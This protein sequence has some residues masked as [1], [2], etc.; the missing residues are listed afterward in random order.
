MRQRVTIRQVAVGF[1]IAGLAWSGFSLNERAV[2][3]AAAEG[4]QYE[5]GEVRIP[6]ASADEPKRSEL[7]VSLAL[8]H[9][10][11]GAVA[12]SG[13]RKCVT[14]HTNGTY[15]VVR[16]ALSASLG[17]P[18]EATWEFFRKTLTSLQAEERSSLRRSTK[19]AQVI[20][21]AAGL[22]EW[23]AHVS[24][25]LLPE[26]EQ[27]LG[28]MFEI[29][30]ENGTWGTLDCWPPYESDAYHEATV[31]A[32]AA[33]TAPGYL[34]KVEAS[35]N[36]TLKKSIERLQTYLRNQPPLHDYSRILL[37]WAS[38]RWPN[39]I[40]STRQAELIEVVR[41]HQ[42]EDGGW[43]IRTFATPEAW[44]RGNRAAKLRAET[45]F[46]TPASDGHMTGLA[47]V[48][49]RS[50]GVPATD[51]AIAR[52]IQWIKTNQ[53]VSG[54]WWTRSLNTDSWH[55]ITYSGTAFPLLALDL[56][57]EI[58]AAPQ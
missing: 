9:L 57:G 54:R 31:A 13:Q 37:L 30:E 5:F 10:E 19:P 20:Y 56:C 7:S 23:D 16:P 48:A 27:A 53:R 6:A 26:T 39:L 24:G 47:V 14:C 58:K 52:G 49:L 21:V 3:V 28:L 36:E 4:V 8:Q 55:F 22:A 33:A 35:D 12:W 32:M 42:R 34:A 11:E 50:A 41:K 1:V 29:Q 38:S 45:D 43:S 15:M 51:P 40:D 17:K 2:R 44:G 25:K 46:E 18:P